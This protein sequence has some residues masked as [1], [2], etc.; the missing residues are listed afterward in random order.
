MAKNKVQ[1]DKEKRIELENLIIDMRERIEADLEYQLKEIYGLK[2]KENDNLNL[3][4]EEIEKRNDLIKAVERETVSDHSWKEAID[5]YIKNTGYTIVNRLTALRCMEARGF[6]E[7]AVTK[8]RDDDLTPGAVILVEEEFLTHEEAIFEAYANQCEELEKEIEILFNSD[9][10]YSILKPKL[11]TYKELCKMMDEIEPEIWLADDVLGWIYEYYNSN[12]LSEVRRKAR[13]DGLDPEDT[14]IANQFYTPHWVVRML[15]DNSLGKLYLEKTNS[16]QE[17]IETQKQFTVE[18]RK[19]RSTSSEEAPGLTELCTYLVP[20]KEE[21]GGE[22]TEFDDPEEIRVIDPACG[23]GHFL[24]YAFDVLERIWWHERPDISKA[25]V[26]SLILEHNLY[27]IDLDL[28]ACQLAAFNLYLK[29][30]GRAEAEGADDFSLPTLNIV[31]SDAKI[32]NLEEAKKLIEQIT[33]KEKSYLQNALEDILEVFEKVQGLGSLLDVKGKIEDEFNKVD[34]NLFVEYD[35]LEVAISDLHRKIEERNDN[36]DFL[37]KDLEDFLRLLKILTSEYDVAL[38]NPPYGSGYGSSGRMPEEIKDY[39]LDH[40]KYSP[41]YYINFFEVCNNLLKN[42]G[43]VG[44]LVPRSF[45]FK[46]TFNDF[47]KDFIEGE[48]IIDFL[49]EY[50]GGILDGATVNTAGTVVRKTKGNSEEKT[51]FIRLHDVETNK[52]EKVFLETICKEFKHTSRLYSQKLRGF[53]LVPGSPISYWVPREIREV[54]DENNYILD[55]ENA[56]LDISEGNQSVGNVKAGLQTGKNDRFVHYHWENSCLNGGDMELV[57]FA[58]GGEEAWVLPK[59]HYVLDWKSNGKKLK[60]YK[61]SVTRNEDF[62]F[63]EAITFNLIKTKDGRRFGFLNKNS[64]FDVA[65]SVFI[66]E[67]SN[68]M[69]DYIS[70]LNSYL[71]NYLVLCQT[72]ERQWNVGNISRLPWKNSISNSKVGELSKKIAGLLLSLRRYEFDSPYYVEPLLLTSFNVNLNLKLYADHP[73]RNLLEELECINLKSENIKK[74]SSLVE[75][76]NEIQKYWSKIEKLLQDNYDKTNKLIFKQFNIKEEI[77]QEIID[78]IQLR[79]AEDPRNAELISEPP[80]L[81]LLV[82]RMLLHLVLKTVLEESDG[83]I[84]LSRESV[85][86]ENIL[87]RLKEKF[88]DIFEKYAEERLS[89]ADSILGDKSST[90]ESY[91]NLRNWL[92]NE[93]FEFHVKEFENTPILWQ[94][95]SKNLVSQPQEAGFACLIDYHRLEQDT[96]DRLQV[97]YLEPRKAALRERRKAANQRRNDTSLSATERQKADDEYNRCENNLRQIEEFEFCIQ[98]LMREDERDWS[99]ENQTLAAEIADKAEQFRK[100]VEDKLEILDKLYQSANNSWFKDKFSPKFFENIEENRDEWL[101]GLKDLKEAGEQY[102]QS[103]KE[104]VESHLYDLFVYA[105]KLLGSTHYSSNGA[106]FVYYYYKKGAKY[107]NGAG[108]PKKGLGENE[109]LMATLAQ[110]LESEI[111]LGE[112]LQEKC[113]KIAKE[114]PSEWKARAYQEITVTGYQPNKKHGVRINIKPLVEAEIVPALVEEKVL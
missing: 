107:L 80:S 57:P 72:P 44:M 58:K 96:F 41:E 39:V 21:A 6:I 26:P 109:K 56:G 43:R 37:A 70:Y 53:R 105:D 85:D 36:A 49:A 20:S 47:R 46:D 16:V 106:L 92:Q 48:G 27:G 1:L 88:A 5:Y 24:L 25:E 12:D 73:Y 14:T 4:S 8:F 102:S 103:S 65:G 38:M 61:G 19:E 101:K 7:R 52:K 68:K 111:E 78:E 60:R 93:L 104:P 22:A 69:W 51:R 76:Y 50:G 81:E 113:K 2:Q 97:K 83:I 33:D 32:V 23:S 3:G 82:K 94:L 54:Y 112:E 79:M 95:T 15:T 108:E 90:E 18:E 31:C 98:N 9:S 110:G 75:I 42:D 29:A 13:E 28:R 11:S 100:I 17:T 55:L 86:E 10:P 30:R 59:V 67:E 40:Y 63:Q 35:D 64:I 71:G 99:E 77:Q 34:D 87:I 84:L 62:Y 45:M 89:E 66:P 114:I 91:P 74:G